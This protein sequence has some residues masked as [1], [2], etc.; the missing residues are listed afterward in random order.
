MPIKKRI[1]QV[2]FEAIIADDDF[3]SRQE[4]TDI[5]PLAQSIFDDGLLQPIGVATRPQDDGID[6][7]FL[8]YGFRRYRALKLLRDKHG[9]EYYSLLEVVVNEGTLDELRIRNLKENIERKSLSSYEISQQVRRM[10]LAG[11][12][13]RDIGIRLGRPQ[14]W[15]SNHYK[16]ATK[17]S[18]AAQT[19][20]RNGEL[21]MD[22]AL[23]LA[24]V[25][26]DEQKG[27][28]TKVL[29]TEN[30]AEQKQILKQAAS[31]SGKKRK[32]TGRSRPSAKN[33]VEFVSE[34]SFQ[35][36]SPIYTEEEKIFY[37]GVAAG[38]RIALGDGEI[39]PKKLDQR[40]KYSDPNYSKRNVKKEDEVSE[41]LAEDV[42]SADDEE[43][44]S[45]SEEPETD[46]D[47]LYALPATTSAEDLAAAEESR[48]TYSDVQELAPPDDEEQYVAEKT[49][50]QA[51]K[52]IDVP[53][54]KRK[55]GRPR[56]HPRPEESQA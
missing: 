30:K 40:E 47:D 8:V 49:G 37:N 39:D 2:P 33:M 23:Y 46:S 16:A 48:R 7:Y 32:Y 38:L 15:V 34:Y 21:T 36:E 22:Q 41:E 17:L 42:S 10:V 9:D 14:S 20:L 28:V 12:D 13:Q 27:L 18:P 25:S 19:A 4:Y 1:I 56:K 35:A 53:P 51:I 3:N 45:L 29:E 50:I 26:E 43:V 54:T 24:D 5:E 52:G 55:R 11:F 31:E 6:K 44:R